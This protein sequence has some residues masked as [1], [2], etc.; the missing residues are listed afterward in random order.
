MRWLAA[1]AVFAWIGSFLYNSAATSGPE[2]VTF[3]DIAARAGVD[4]VLRNSATPERHQIEPMVA[5]VAIFDFNNDGRPDLYFVNG[6]RQPRFDKPDAGWFNRLYRNNGDGTFTDVTQRAGLKGVGFATGV[7]IADYDNDGWE[8]VF[9]AGV[10]RNILY[11]NRGDGTFEDV[12]AHAGLNPAAGTPKPWSVSA[13][14]FDYDNDGLLDLMVVNY[15]RWSPEHD[16]PC[17]IGKARTYCHPKY[18]EGLPNSLY[19][20]NGDGTFTDVSAASGIAAHVGKSMSVSFLDYDQDG[21]LDM[22]VANDTTP[23]FLFHNEGGG[24]FRET[25]TTA[26]VAFNDDGRAVSSMGVDARDLDNDGL[27]DLFV[28]ANQSETFP[29]FRNLGKAFFSDITYASGTGSQT[30][31][32]TG[33]SAGI[34]DFNNDG[35]KDLFAACGAIDDNVE[36]FSHRSSR[37]TNLVLANA[38]GRRFINVTGSAG[39]D[40]QRAAWHR[41]AAFGDLDGDGRVDVVVSRIGERAAVFRNMSANRNHFLAVRLRGHR[42]NRDGIGA[43]IHVKG[44]SGREQWNRV[45]TAVGYGSSSDRTA[46]FG[47]AGDTTAWL[48]ILWPSGVHQIQPEVKTDRYWTFE[49]P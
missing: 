7:A 33:W 16:P 8:D 32:F 39:R 46:F 44:A 49:E 45:T 20:N 19:H 41:G 9:I 13:G 43:M 35:F 40:L 18:Y 38:G 3:E 30:L 15:C 27:E 12:T 36:E 47:M 25:A 29:L 5:G 17:S 1:V 22:F 48:E 42:S 24:K 37:Q 26:G 10:D 6:A 34:F 31:P 2:P 21:L 11:R 28:T 14:W 23:N 4:F